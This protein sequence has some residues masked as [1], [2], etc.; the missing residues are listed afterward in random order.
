MKIFIG[1]I[2]FAVYGAKLS[3]A[4]NKGVESFVKDDNFHYFLSHKHR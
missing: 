4:R 1:L 2:T 3:R